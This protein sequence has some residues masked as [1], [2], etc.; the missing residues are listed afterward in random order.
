MTS[1]VEIDARPEPARPTGALIAAGCLVLLLVG[2][3]LAAREVRV[4]GARVSSA[5][6]LHALMDGLAYHIEPLRTGGAVPRLLLQR[7]PAGME[8]LEATA[9]RKDTFLR[10]LLPLVLAA[11]EAVLAERA[12]VMGLRASLAAGEE[13]SGSE[14]RRIAALAARYRVTAPADAA[15]EA[16]L[17]RL[18][19]RIDA[20]PPS[21][22]LAQAAV[23]S[24][25]GTSRFAR[26]GNAL[27]GQ[28]DWT[29]AGMAPLGHEGEPPYRIAAFDSLEDCV[30]AYVANLNS[31][32]A[33]A[34]FR[35]QRAEQRAA[36]ATDG[37]AL[38]AT[39]LAY[40][41]TGQVYIET[42]RAVIDDND[43]AAFDRARLGDG[44]TLLVMAAR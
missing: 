18:L 20:V 2:G 10:A 42:L 5:G 24:G 39:M 23:E 15:T 3:A 19:L 31:H 12:E 34:G 36:G 27:F 35:R 22:A 16:V 37:R 28:S 17:D 21:L 41:E 9:E 14:R 38:A 33:Y 26:E 8:A 4:D 7:L 13:L 43:L 1:N 44:R 30:A 40:A 6:E 25:W 29:E 11:N 32:P